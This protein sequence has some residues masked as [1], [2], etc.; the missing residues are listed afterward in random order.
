MGE[1]WEGVM[2][3]PHK[4]R[5]E[6]ASGRRAR[7]RARTL[8]QNM[9]EA[10]WR[11]W[12]I[13]RSEQIK[14]YKFR[15]Q[16]PIS[17]Y[18]ADFVCH[19]ARLIVEVDGGQH[20]RSS[21]PEAKRSEFLQNEGYRILRFWNNQVLSSLDGVHQTIAEELRHITPTLTLLHQGGG[22]D[23][24]LPRRGRAGVEVTRAKATGADQ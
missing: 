12:Q 21:P 19:D 1:G 14:G 24:P 18:I 10:E 9:T 4:L 3:P 22:P 5:N 7:A 20:G 2:L 16:V 23:H 13:L 8:R 11:V 17:R 6:E 15:R